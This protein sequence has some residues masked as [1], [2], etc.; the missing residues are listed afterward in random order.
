MANILVVSGSY[1]PYASANAVCMKKFEDALKDRGHN[2]IYAIKK[3]DI[4]QPEK[5]R[6]NDCDVYHIPKTSD[7]FFQTIKKL[8]ELKL[9]GKMNKAFELSFKFFRLI[10]KIF[11]KFSRKDMHKEANELYWNDYAK[12]IKEIIDSEK[13]DL[14]ISISVPFDSHIAVLRAFNMMKSEQSKVAG[15]LY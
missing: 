15:L 10:N 6:I 9:P 1:F 13:I 12:K 7:L 8:R 3:R 11:A 2:V 14:V 4:S 5:E